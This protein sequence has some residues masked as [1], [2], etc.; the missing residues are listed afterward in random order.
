MLGVSFAVFVLVRFIPGDP[1]TLLIAESELSSPE[2]VAAAKQRLGLD[3]PLLVQYGLYLSNLARGD[4]GRSIRSGRPVL[5]EISPRFANTVFLALAAI[6]VTVVVGIPL[7][8]LAAVKKDTFFDRA[9]MITALMGISAPIFWLGLV[10][11]IVFALWLGWLPSAGKGTLAHLILPVVTLGLFPVANVARLVRTS[12]LEVLGQEY[13]TAA[14]AKGLSTYAL[15]FRHA[16]RNALI[17]AVTV[18]GLSFGYML[19]GAVITE[20]VFAW[21]GVGR[22]LVRA[23]FT[24]D[25]PVIQG[26][27]LCIALSYVLVNFITDVVYT[28]LDP[29]IRVS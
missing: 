5:E 2:D 6:L 12:M 14:R 13:M 26:I 8:V 22:Y 10:L 18:I 21:P 1:V 28:L 17:P 15:L 23:I 3:R 11:Q 29:R 9:S 7:G 4:L 25:Y 24:R 27:I 20:V 19:G 16:L